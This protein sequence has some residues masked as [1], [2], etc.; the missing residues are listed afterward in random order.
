MFDGGNW[1]GS[2]PEIKSIVMSL[3]PSMARTQA[4]ELEELV[5]A[6]VELGQGLRLCLSERDSEVGQDRMDATAASMGSNR[7]TL[8][9]L[10]Y[11]GWGSPWGNLELRL[12]IHH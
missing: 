6:L 10:T 8:C 9:V 3:Y 2:A 7:A 12:I 4:W 11:R 1:V 5:P